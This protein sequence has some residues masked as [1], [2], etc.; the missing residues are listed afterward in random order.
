MDFRVYFVIED[1]NTSSHTYII[2]CVYMH[3]Y[4]YVS[5]MGLVQQFYFEELIFFCFLTFSL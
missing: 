4:T 5:Y 3:A 2:M 1:I